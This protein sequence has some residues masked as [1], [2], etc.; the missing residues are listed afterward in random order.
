VKPLRQYFT[1]LFQPTRPE[2]LAAI[3]NTLL[4][5]AVPVALY[6][7]AVMAF[8]TSNV[9]RARVSTNFEF[10]VRT[11]FE[12]GLF[13]T[14]FVT[15]AAVSGWRT[16]VHARR[17]CEQHGGG[18]QGVAEAGAVGL[19]IA[20]VVLARGIITRPRDAP[21]YV[22]VYGGAALLIGLGIGLVLRFTAILVIKLASR[23]APGRA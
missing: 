21:P 11:I 19:F 13:F 17:Y 6:V 16:L 4:V 22:V 18:W 2:L 10:F 12:V 14:P 3:V 9:A 20:L 1:D 7:A 5:L 23:A 15:L 8:T